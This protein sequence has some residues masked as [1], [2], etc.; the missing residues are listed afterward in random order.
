MLFLFIVIEKSRLWVEIMIALITV[1]ATYIVF[2]RWLGIQLP[3]EYLGF[4]PAC[5]RKTKWIFLTIFFTVFSVGLQP[6]NLFILFCWMFNRD[7]GRSSSWNL[8][9]LG[10]ISIL[11]SVT[12]RMSPVSAIIMLAGIF[13]GA[14]YGGSTTSI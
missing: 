13:Y 2:Y 6:E 1:S 10:A 11:L 12:F 8:A 5:S 3:R 14:M 9:R 4:R 7:T